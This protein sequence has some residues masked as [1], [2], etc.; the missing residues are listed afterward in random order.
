MIRTAT[1]AGLG[2]WA[3][4]ARRTP[5]IRSPAGW[6]RDRALAVRYLY[7]SCRVTREWLE[8]WSNRKH[9]GDK[10]PLPPLRLRNGVLLKHGEVENPVG[11]LKEAFLDRW[12]ECGAKPPADTRMVD[13]GAKSIPR[14]LRPTSSKV[15]PPALLNATRSVIVEYHDNICPGHRR[16]VGGFSTRQAF[17]GARVHPFVIPIPEA[18]VVE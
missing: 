17:A 14:A 13:I 1:P 12:Y 7:R 5:W 10:G 18:E 15:R 3:D 2:L 16:D 4:R 9:S 6:V 8:V 11:L